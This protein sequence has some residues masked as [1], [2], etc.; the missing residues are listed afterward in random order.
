ML[1]DVKR[2]GA[3]YHSDRYYHSFEGISAARTGAVLEET[4]AK[5]VNP[6]LGAHQRAQKMIENVLEMVRSPTRTQNLGKELSPNSL[7]VWSFDFEESHQIKS[8]RFFQLCS[9]HVFL[10]YGYGAETGSE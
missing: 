5:A 1:L 4:L 10:S 9:F 6:I 8:G 3:F 2:S 7:G